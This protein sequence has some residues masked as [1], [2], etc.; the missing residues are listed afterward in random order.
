MQSIHVKGEKNYFDTV[1]HL[2][3]AADVN[4]CKLQLFYIND[5]QLQLKV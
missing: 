4:E 5:L 3:D 1:S 2:A